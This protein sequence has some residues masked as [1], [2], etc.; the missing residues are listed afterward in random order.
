MRFIIVFVV[1]LCVVGGVVLHA[2]QADFRQR[3]F[4]GLEVVVEATLFDTHAI[5]DVA[6]T[7][8]VITTLGKYGSRCADSRLSLMF[9]FVGAWICHKDSP[10]R[11]SEIIYSTIEI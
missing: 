8:A 5:S 4:L 6:G 2:E 1:A 11:G 3:L 7:G 10:P 9:V